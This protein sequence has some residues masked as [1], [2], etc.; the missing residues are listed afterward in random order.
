VVQLQAS[1]KP[2]E[3]AAAQGFL[4]PLKAEACNHKTPMCGNASQFVFWDCI[5]PS[6]VAHQNLA[7][8]LE[9]K[10]LPI[11]STDHSR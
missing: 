8:N 2:T 4:K 7:K 1:W 3:G 6:Q 5:H 10:I 11:L 9:E